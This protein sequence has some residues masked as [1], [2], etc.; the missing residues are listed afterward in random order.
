MIHDIKS[1]HD[2]LLSAERER[3]E[4]DIA[5]SIQSSLIPKFSD[6]DPYEICGKMI[7]A[8]QVGGDYLD[9]ITGEV[10][11]KLWIS[12][13]DVSGHGLAAGLIMMM[14]QT[15]FN[16]IMLNK[17]DTGTADLIQRVNRVLHQ[18]IKLRLGED[19]FMTI[20]CLVLDPDGRVSYAGA[21]LDILVWRAHSNSVEKIHT[22]GIWMGIMP[23]ISKKTIEREFNLDSGDIML[24]YTDGLIEAPDEDLV[25]Y[26]MERLEKAFTGLS[27]KPVAS[28]MDGILEDAFGFM[29]RQLDD[30]TLLVLRK[31]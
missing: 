16:T 8:E 6:H 20:S 17:P 14:A 12:V 15:A 21:H 25:Q 9:L 31:K 19:D 26:D 18:N 22:T 4:M 2:R 30:I 13:G 3:A 7:P 27:S 23:D 5:N 10:E 1:F 11:G 24:L 29:E 28:I